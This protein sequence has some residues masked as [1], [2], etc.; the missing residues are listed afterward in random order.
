MSAMNNLM[1]ILG[2]TSLGASLVKAKL[3]QRFVGEIASVITLAI[4]TGLMAGALLVGAFFVLY[5][6]LVHYGLEPLPAQVCVIGLALGTVAFLTKTLTDKLRGLRSIPERIVHTE[7]PFSGHLNA[8]A[9]SFMEG[10]LK[11]ADQP[12]QSKQH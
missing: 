11:S 6:A 10:F 8:L 9:D 12:Q 1:R 4:A 5:E 3:V 7:L 2:I